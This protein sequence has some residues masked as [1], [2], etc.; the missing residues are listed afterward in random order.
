MQELVDK[1]KNEAGLTDEQAQKAAEIVKGFVL[2]KVPP[3]FAGVVEG[4][5]AGGAVPGEV[6]I[7]G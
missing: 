5:F 4:F 2:S 7:M 6:D 3:M 1:L